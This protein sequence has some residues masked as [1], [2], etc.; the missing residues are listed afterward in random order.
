M[1]NTQLAMLGIKYSM[2]VAATN[3]PVSGKGKISLRIH[4]N[5]VK[6]KTFIAGI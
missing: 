3:F 5:I 6:R 4:A 2:F 1:N